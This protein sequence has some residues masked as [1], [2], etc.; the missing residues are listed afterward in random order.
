LTVA[1]WKN[2]PVEAKYA[3]ETF[4]RLKKANPRLNGDREWDH[5]MRTVI[6]PH[7]KKDLPDPGK[8]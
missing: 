3:P 1:Q 5:F 6:V 4:D 8:G 7:R 2:L